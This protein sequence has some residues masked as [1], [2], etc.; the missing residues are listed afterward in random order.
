M[1]LSLSSLYY[2]FY[3]LFLSS[4][5]YRLLMLGLDAA[6][7]TTVLYKLKV[8]FATRTIAVARSS[9]LVSA[10]DIPTHTVNSHFDTFILRILHTATAGRSSQGH[11]DDWFQRRNG[12]VPQH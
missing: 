10:R 2:N 12:R 5:E 1:G 3:N 9:V 8:R 4:K 7:K 11:S 6:G